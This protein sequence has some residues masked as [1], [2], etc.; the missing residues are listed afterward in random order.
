[1][2][3]LELLLAEDDCPYDNSDKQWLRC[4]QHRA[5][6]RDQPLLLLLL[7][8]YA[9][10]HHWSSAKR[11]SVCQLDS[12]EAIL[13]AVELPISDTISWLCRSSTKIDSSVELVHYAPSELKALYQCLHHGYFDPIDQ[14]YLPD[15]LM[16]LVNLARLLVKH[17]ELATARFIRR[18]KHHTVCFDLVEFKISQIK[19]AAQRLCIAVD[20][21]QKKLLRC[22]H[23]TDLNRLQQRLEHQLSDQLLVAL[24]LVDWLDL[25]AV[26]ECAEAYLSEVELLDLERHWYERY[27]SLPWA[28]HEHIVQLTEYPML[29][30]EA[31]SQHNCALTYRHELESQDYAIFKVL[32]PERATLALKWQP[33]KQRFVLDQLE[34]A[35]N[36]AV[37]HATRRFVRRWINT[38]QQASRTQAQVRGI[39]SW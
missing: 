23:L 22:R 38:A 27:P 18:S 24:Q 3:L 15:D 25:A 8:Y 32:H 1:M 14:R 11:R 12:A 29:F 7:Q 10:K 2:S 33:K 31:H 17:P 9:E 39:S 28:S 37:S 34:V 21:M 16:G 5:L 13:Q 6:L 20:D 4:Y 19:S 30:M 36:Q 26:Y 35:N